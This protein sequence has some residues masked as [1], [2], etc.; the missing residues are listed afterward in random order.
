M[1]PKVLA[2]TSALSSLAFAAICAGSI[3]VL[4]RTDHSCAVSRAFS[5]VGALISRR[6]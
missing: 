6:A 5:S 1:A 4:I 3:P 2:R